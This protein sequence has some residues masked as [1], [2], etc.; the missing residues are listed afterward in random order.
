MSVRKQRI[1][2]V[3]NSEKDLKIILPAPRQGVFTIIFSPLWL[4]GWTLG[5]IIVSY[6]LF[7]PHNIFTQHDP[8]EPPKLLM[9]F[10]LIFWTIGGLN[11]WWSIF[12]SLAGKEIISVSNYRMTLCREVFGI[13]FTRRFERRDIRPLR[14][15]IESGD[16]L[17][18]QVHADRQRILTPF[19]NKGPIAFVYRSKTYRFGEGIEKDEAREVAD[20]LNEALER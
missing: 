9:V 5:E 17:G 4:I 16:W 12:W 20:R 3:E 7:T 6:N 14:L 1:E 8:S 13:R 19:D 15:F 10:W 11:V 2:V 18:L